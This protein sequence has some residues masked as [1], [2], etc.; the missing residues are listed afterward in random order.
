[1]AAPPGDDRAWL[2]LG[3]LSE[4]GRAGIARRAHDESGAAIKI[5]RP[6]HGRQCSQGR[7]SRSEGNEAAALMEEY[8]ARRKRPAHQRQRS[9]ELIPN[10]KRI[11]AA[12]PLKPAF[13]PRGPCRE[14]Q[15][16]I[17]AAVERPDFPA[18]Q[19]CDVH[20]VI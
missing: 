14:Q 8:G 7:R 13:G 9:F 18:E 19:A 4:E 11:I 20:A 5:E 6:W 15:V 12:E 16:R 17:S 10:G 3:K 2:H 1:M